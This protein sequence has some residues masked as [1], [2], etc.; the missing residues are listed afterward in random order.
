M[1]AANGKLLVAVNASGKIS[2]ITIACVMVSKEGLKTSTAVEPAG[3]AIWIAE[4]CAGK[5]VFIPTPKRSER[6]VDK[7]RF[8]V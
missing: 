6:L 3:D 8:Y 1:R 7:S 5:A 4:R 2:V